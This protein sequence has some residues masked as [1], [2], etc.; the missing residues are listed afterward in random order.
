MR[1]RSFP[2]MI[3]LV[4]AAA[5]L[6]VTGVSAL[7][8]GGLFPRT[9]VTTEE[10]TQ[11]P[12]QRPAQL[13]RA[14][15]TRGHYGNLNEAERAAYDLILERLPR[16]PES[17]RLA[18]LSTEGLDR[19]FAALVLDQPLLFHISTTNYTKLTQEGQATAFMPEY[20]MGREEY[21]ARC[22]A[23]AKAV[24]TF[25]VPAGGTPF[26]CELA[27]HDQLIRR[28]AYAEDF[29]QAEKSTAYGALV[30]GSASCEG[31]ARAFQLLMDLQ[32]IDCYIVTGE[33]TNSA[34]DAVGHAW[35]KVRVEG[36]WYQ[37]DAT[38]ND[39]V[40]EDGSHVTSHAYFNLTDEEI[41]LSHELTDTR[42]PC[43]ATA[44]NYY[45]RKGLEFSGL[46]R[47]AEDLLTKAL[48]DG[49]A[50]GDNAAELRFKDGDAMKEGLRYLF[51]RQNIYRV[52]NNAALG[53][54]DIRTDTLFHADLTPLRVVR[55]LPVKK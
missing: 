4:L 50:A 47:A 11:P 19:V 29:T 38:W 21:A 40:T 35:N 23:L 45:I 24:E 53:G 34:G 46:D 3:L 16:F 32:G 8:G 27:L 7:R 5:A 37:T 39:P 52:L 20:R 48:R 6:A 54:A 17:I 25:A 44:A 12:V 18:D 42:N 15:H 28:C 51:D 13:L 31:Y 43:T 33:A 9:E 22:E 36:E 10:P 30:E 26:D 1:R 41:G 14:G 49:M 55:L 2:W